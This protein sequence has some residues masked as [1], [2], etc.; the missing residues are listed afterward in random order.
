M[1]FY[2]HLK[3]KDIKISKGVHMKSKK[4]FTLCCLVSSVFFLFSCGGGGSGSGDTGTLSLGL[5]DAATDNFQ[6]IYVTISEI[7]VHRSEAAGGEES[8][9]ITVA[10]PGKTFNL[11]D[12]MNGV[13]EPL[14]AAPL[15]VGTYSQTRL[16]L[17]ET[18]DGEDNILGVTHPHAN[19][20]ILDDDLD[21]VKE[22]TV[23]SGYQTGVKLIREFEIVAGLTVDL[24]VDF[25]ASSSVVVA[26][27]SGKYQLKP[28]V[29]ITDTVDN[30]LLSGTV[31]EN[32]SEPVYLDRALVS[33]QYY[34]EGSTDPIMF[35]ATQAIDGEYLMYLPPNTY[36]VV[37][38]KS[39][40]SDN[41]IFEPVCINITTNLNDTLTE[42]IALI[43][44][45]PIMVNVNVS[46]LPTPSSPED[47]PPN[48]T[49][50]FR[51]EQECAPVEGTQVIEVDKLNVSGNGDF[52]ILLPAGM[53]TYV[54]S[55]EGMV[56]VPG[57]LNTGSPTLTID[58]VTE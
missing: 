43:A 38:Y 22:L 14:G 44:G 19:Y 2:L 47:P 40:A 51:K 24:V 29:K 28:T 20:V 46:G 16:Y 30:A 42:N 48:A 33:A 12:L 53:Y 49:I 56:T 18:H 35:T 3:L 7:K 31:T 23:S 26:G 21:T 41:V 45:T 50:S 15:D 17:G 58:F 39:D 34:E 54:A 25:D 32:S 55:S 10:S 11:M 13:I 27:N 6:A 4:L 1:A 5:T 57:D 36:N 8:G 37:A 52:T 9:W